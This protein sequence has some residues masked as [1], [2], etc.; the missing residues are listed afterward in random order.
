MQELAALVQALMVIAVVGGLALLAHWGR[1]SRGAEISLFVVLL[2]LSFLTPALGVLVALAGRSPDLQTQGLTSTVFLGVAGV[3]LVGGIAG[4]ALCVPPLRRIT[5]RGRAPVGQ[6]PKGSSGDDEEPGP[7]S[8][9]FWSDPPIF[10]AL[11]LFVAVLTGNL[12][13]LIAFAAA[14]GAVGN[15]LA[16]TGRVSPLTVVL[17]ELPLAVVALLGVG[18]GVDRDLRGAVRRLGYGPIPP[19]RL[20]PVAAFVVGAVLLSFAANA[21]FSAIQPDL[22]ERVGRIS[23]GLLS[24]QGMSLLGVIFFG[25]VIGIGAALGEE[26]LFRGALQPVLGIVPTSILFASVH[27]QYGPSLILLYIFALSVGL[28]LLRKY[29]N[30]TASFVVHAAYNFALVLASYFLSA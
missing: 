13:F 8:G 24:T 3:L 5:S 18:F 1:R 11:W 4:L 7:R 29:I 27:V 28:G 15:A 12:V 16:Q 20:G 10:L 22:A 25:L 17:G 30:T 26:T 21:A 2:F 9:G 23:E 19:R 14:P 6:V